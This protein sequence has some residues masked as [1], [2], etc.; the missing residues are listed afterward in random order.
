MDKILKEFG[1]HLLDHQFTTGNF[2]QKWLRNFLTFSTIPY[3][4]CT[5]LTQCFLF[6]RWIEQRQ[7]LQLNGYVYLKP[8]NDFTNKDW[9]ICVDTANESEKKI[10][11]LNFLTEIESETKSWLLFGCVIFMIVYHA[12]ESAI[13]EFVATSQSKPLLTFL[14]GKPRSMNQENQDHE[15]QPIDVQGDI[16]ITNNEENNS[17]IE[18]N[19]NQNCIRPVNEDSTLSG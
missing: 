6:D 18:T 8:R 12:L 17:L 2:F 7:I 13:S 1:C 14:L 3:L 19:G 4:A 16:T 5:T 10:N 9:N 11:I 15:L